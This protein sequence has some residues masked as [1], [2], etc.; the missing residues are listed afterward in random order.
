MRLLSSVLCICFGLCDT[1]WAGSPAQLLRGEAPLLFTGAEGEDGNS[2]LL[3][4]GQAIRGDEI[5]LWVP[6][7]DGRTKWTWVP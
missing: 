7:I 1:S 4:D 3:L 2:T 5:W 6:A